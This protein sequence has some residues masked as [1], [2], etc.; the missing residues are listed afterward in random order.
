MGG[1]SGA[2]SEALSAAYLDQIMSLFV[3]YSPAAF[4]LTQIQVPVLTVGPGGPVG[5]YHC[6]FHR[7]P[8]LFSSS[9]APPAPSIPLPPPLVSMDDPGPLTFL[10]FSVIQPLIQVCTDF[11]SSPAQLCANIGFMEQF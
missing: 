3:Q 9:S 10:A 2:V 11:T 7:Y 5:P 6:L 4:F 1:D 8:P